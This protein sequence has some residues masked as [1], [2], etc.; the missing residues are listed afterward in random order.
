MS[1]SVLYE[2]VE[3]P[4]GDI[5]LQRADEQ[6]EPLVSIRFSKESLYFLSDSKIT[7]AKAM[8]EAGLEAAGDI[9]DNQD[10]LWDDA[11]ISDHKTLH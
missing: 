1:Q 3:L 2:I 7:V 10:D 9:E 11:L 4:N 6:G 8:I 5:A